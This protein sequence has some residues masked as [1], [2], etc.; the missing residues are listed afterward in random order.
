MQTTVHKA[1]ESF[2]LDLQSQ[3]LQPSKHYRTMK[4]YLKTLPETDVLCIGFSVNGKPYD[5]TVANALF[6]LRNV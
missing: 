4:A 3:N 5:Y 2:M 1:Y 6:N